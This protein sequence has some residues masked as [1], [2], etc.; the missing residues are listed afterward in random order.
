MENPGP[1]AAVLQWLAVVEG[2]AAEHWVSSSSRT[3][4]VRPEITYTSDLVMMLMMLI[5]S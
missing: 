1:E 4:A 3:T 5:I 2:L